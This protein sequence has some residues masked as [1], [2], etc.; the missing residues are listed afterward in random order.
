[1]GKTALLSATRELVVA[2]GLASLAARGGELERDH[3]YGV[4]RQ[5]LEPGLAALSGAE[6][7]EAL[8]GAAELAQP[9]LGGKGAVPKEEQAAHYGLYWTCAN[10]AARRPLALLVDDAHWSD[11]A[12]LRFLY[13]LAR[14]VNELPLL[15]VLTVRSDEAGEH[16]ALFE[17]LA[18]ESA[19]AVIRPAPLSIGA[20]REVVAT[21]LSEPEDAFTVACRDATGG[22]PFLLKELMRTLAERGLEPSAEEIGRIEHAGP[23][24]VARNVLVRLKRLGP[25][26]ER[27]AV[28]TAILDG[29]ELHRAAAVAD[30][31]ISAAADAADALSAAGLLADARPLR[32]VHPLVRSAI[33]DS[34]RAGAAA[35]AHRRAASVLTRAAAAPETVAAHL[36]AADP[37]IGPEAVATLRAAAERSVERGAPEVAVLHYERALRE[38]LS[39]AERAELLLALGRADIDA[40]PLQAKA[41]LLEAYDLADDSMVRAHAARTLAVLEP[42]YGTDSLR[43]L[44]DAVAALNGPEGASTGAAARTELIGRLRAERLAI[45]VSA[46]ALDLDAARALDELEPPT[47]VR[48][49]ADGLVLVSLARYRLMRGRPAAEVVPLVERALASR[50]VRDELGRERLWLVNSMV[51]LL[52]GDRLEQAS[53]MLEEVVAAARAGGSAPLFALACAFRAVVALQNGAVEEAEAEARAALAA[54][55][56]DRWQL[57]PPLGTLIE[58]LL[59]RG[60][61]EEAEQALELAGLTD[62]LPDVRPYTP[63]LIA[64]GRL[65]A[66]AG[67]AER[68]LEDL[69]EAE[70]RLDRSG[71]GHP[72]GLDGRAHASLTLLGLGRRGEA[73]HRAEEDLERAQRWGTPRVVG[74][75]LRVHA[76]TR[77][78]CAMLTELEEAI[79]C[80]EHSPARLELGRALADYGGALR[81]A[82]RRADART[83]LRCALALAEECRADALAERAREELAVTGARVPRTDRQG[84]ESLTPSEKRI[85]EMAAGGLSN[86]AIAQALFVTVK[87]VEMHLGHAYRKLDIRSRTELPR[88]LAE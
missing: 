70:R 51:I 61:T 11:L 3:P 19:A 35:E 20:V 32:F 16:R 81:R 38:D 2:A 59:E 29:A 4:V 26:A 28:A 42:G 5:L 88:A 77:E 82:N 49:A 34:L 36:L 21:E 84:Q 33:A 18:A 37:G 15:V 55:G 80:L 6:R 68:A 45:T 72:V 76:L 40:R 9:L 8:S 50:A 24:A 14:R 25:E 53:Q 79:A 7:A 69:F 71:G 57:G 85:C 13:F 56:V 65:H 48:A 86:P 75:A 27:L 46:P 67:R 83:P 12:S 66:A 54:E 78:G 10:L 1:M 73:R 74:R 58:A 41:H 62:E 64:R 87:T 44:D 47:S 60:H 39:R 63:L 52:H 30:L 31:P 17:R 43:R 22:N 23:E